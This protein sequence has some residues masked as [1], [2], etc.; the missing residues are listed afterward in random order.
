TFAHIKAGASHKMY[1]GTTM[2]S[3]Q[4][5]IDQGVEV[6]ATTYRGIE[7]NGIEFEGAAPDLGAYEYGSSFTDVKLVKQ[8]SADN[9]VSLFQAQNGLLFVTVNDPAKARDY[10]LNLFDVSG[11]L[12][13][14]HSF[15]GATTAI[16][17]PQ[18][19]EG[20]VVIKV[21]GNNGFVGTAKAVVK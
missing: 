15:N 13:G 12:L 17:L 6:P 4:L 3:E 11:K 21:K 18:G 2:T 7:I 14:Q 20:L 19:A 1:D 16:S 8:E 5:L 9:T 10:T